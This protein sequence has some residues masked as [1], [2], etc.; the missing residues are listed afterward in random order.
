MSK[1]R[2]LFHQTPHTRTF[3]FATS[4]IKGGQLTIE[5]FYFITD[6]ARK[7]HKGGL[8]MVYP[9]NVLALMSKS[10]P[11]NFDPV[12]FGLQAAEDLAKNEVAMIFM[13]KYF[14]DTKADVKD[15]DRRFEF[16]FDRFQLTD[17]TVA[18]LAYYS[19]DEEDLS[20]IYQSKNQGLKD[21]LQAAFLIKKVIQA[22]PASTM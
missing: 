3:I 5:F 21:L 6:E 2:A 9:P 15:I 7:K 19:P 11:A 13:N 18:T 12:E 17:A 1:Y 22:T 16:V 4:E 10:A 8:T 20:F 14:R